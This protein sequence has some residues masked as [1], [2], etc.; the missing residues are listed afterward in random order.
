MAKED[1]L[2]D[3]ET[4]SRQWELHVVLGWLGLFMFGIVGALLGAVVGY[5]FGRQESAVYGALIGFAICAFIGFFVCK[6]ATH[7][8]KQAK[9]YS[10]TFETAK[11]LQTGITEYD[12]F[13]TVHRC[14]NVVSSEGLAGFFGKQNDSFVKVEVGR[15]V[16]DDFMVSEGNPIKMTCVN[17]AN[18]FEETFRLRIARTDEWLR[19]TLFDQDMMNEDHVGDVTIHISEEIVG[20]HFPQERGYPLKAK[21]DQ[22]TG[23]ELHAGTVILSFTPGGNFP[24]DVLQRSALTDRRLEAYRLQEKRGILEH[25]LSSIRNE[26]KTYGTW[27]VPPA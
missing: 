27:A 17:S 11:F 12:L 24:K 21:S 14:Q 4:A 26:A 8:T 2:I 18:E 13:I 16:D 10:P 15:K 19:V 7:Y 5:F 25:D 23:R 3:T 20:E 1:R 6:L 22:K 9:K